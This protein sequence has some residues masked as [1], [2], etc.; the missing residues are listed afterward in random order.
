MSKKKKKRDGKKQ[1]RIHGISRSPSSFLPAERKRSRRTDR[2]TDGRTHPLIESWL[3]TKKQTKEV[4]DQ[5]QRDDEAANLAKK[6]LESYNIIG[7]K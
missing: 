1:C 6:K 5:S 4:Q 7:P 2:R 3:T